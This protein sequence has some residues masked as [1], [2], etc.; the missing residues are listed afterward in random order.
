MDNKLNASILFFII[1]GISILLIESVFDIQLSVFYY[2][3]LTINETFNALISSMPQ[4]G[5]WDESINNLKL[6]MKMVTFLLRIFSSPALL[7][8]AIIYML[9]PKQEWDKMDKELIFEDL[10]L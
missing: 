3:E 4:S 2:Y 10:V 8:A 7:F 5:D 6:L 1:S 9:Y